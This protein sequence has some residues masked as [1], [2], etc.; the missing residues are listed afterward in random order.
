MKPHLLFGTLLTVAL[1]FSPAY[2]QHMNEKDSPCAN[3]V[4]TAEL[5]NCLSNA[6]DKADATLNSVYTNVRKRL[7]GDDAEHLVKT[8]RLWIQYRDA[9]CSAERDLYEGGTARYPAYFACLEAM[10]RARTKELRVT[11]AVR[12]KD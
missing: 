3:V 9:N 8:Q 2:A 11:Y 7:D 5:S 10:T 6:R 1:F 12:L 4:V